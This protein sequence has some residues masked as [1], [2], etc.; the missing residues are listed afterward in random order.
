MPIAL[1]CAAAPSRRCNGCAVNQHTRSSWSVRLVFCATVVTVTV[2]A[3]AAAGTWSFKPTR[4]EQRAIALISAGSLR[5]HLAFLSSNPLQGRGAGTLGVP[6]HTICGTF[7]YPDYHGVTDTW[8]KI[9]YDNMAMTV[10]TI[11][12]GLLMIANSSV[13]PQWNPAVAR[14]SRYLEAWKKLHAR[15]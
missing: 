3:A 6:A 11:A 15:Q 2:A 14:A 9:D 5:A 10:R 8:D 12:S 13:E 4:A 7:Q 1:I